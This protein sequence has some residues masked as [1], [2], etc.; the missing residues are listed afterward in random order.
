MEKY[1][2]EILLYWQKS[3]VAGFKIDEDIIAS[4]MLGGLPDDYQALILGIEN[5]AKELT[6]DY[7]KTV[8]LQGVKDPLE[9]KEKDKALPGIV[10]RQKWKGKAKKNYKGKRRCFKC[11]DTLH[12]VV[13]CPKRDLKCSECGDTRHLAKNCRIK[14]DHKEIRKTEKQKKMRKVSLHFLMFKRRT[15]K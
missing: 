1:I 13:N 8:L 4:L 10:L 5:S 9:P 6:V 14:N 7:V 3:K 15:L 2:N 12:F 11:G